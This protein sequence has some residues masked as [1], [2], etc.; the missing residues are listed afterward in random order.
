MENSSFARLLM[1]ATVFLLIILAM[2]LYDRFSEQIPKT[3]LNSTKLLPGGDPDE[4]LKDKEPAHIAGIIFA[5]AGI[6][7]VAVIFMYGFLKVLSN[8]KK[9]Y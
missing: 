5:A 4:F 6:F 1:F 2:V 3:E 9:R 8:R 7:F